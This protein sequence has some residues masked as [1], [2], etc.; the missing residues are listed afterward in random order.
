MH[1]REYNAKSLFVGK[2]FFEKLSI[3]SDQFLEFEEFTELKRLLDD[4]NV[5]LWRTKIGEQ[6]EN[7]DKS[8][9]WHTLDFFKNNTKNGILKH[10]DMK[11][12][13]NI[14]VIELFRE[15]IRLRTNVL[16]SFSYWAVK[17]RDYM[18]IVYKHNFE[19][20]IADNIDDLL[21]TYSSIEN[22]Y[23][24]KDY[25]DFVIT[26]INEYDQNKA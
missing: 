3:Y 10:W 17:D 5:L 18:E 19:K 1:S 6:F 16:N 8:K 12:K 13:L 9:S 24:E 2:V 11:D 4:S 22:G 14:I 21:R 20:F 25:N 26:K 15:L 7:Y 23:L